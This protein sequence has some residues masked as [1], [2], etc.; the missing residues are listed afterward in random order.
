MWWRLDAMS[1]ECETD[2]FPICT[3]LNVEKKKNLRPAYRP[4]AS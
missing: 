3:Q 1:T 4:G 2:V